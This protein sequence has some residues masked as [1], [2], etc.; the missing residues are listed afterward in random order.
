MRQTVGASDHPSSLQQGLPRATTGPRPSGLAR[1]GER[2]MATGLTA[3][4]VDTLQGARAGSTRRQ[5]DSKWKQFECW[6]MDRDPQVV[7]DSAPVGAVLSFLQS[8]LERGRCY[9]TIKGLVK[10]FL[11]AVK[12]RSATARPLVPAW[13]LAVVLD[14]LCG[15]QFEPIES[16]SLR[17]LSLKTLFLLAITTA[18]RVSD[19]Q[20]LSIHE[21]CFRMDPE[22]RREL[23]QPDLSFVTKN[24]VV[25][26]LPVALLAYHPPPFSSPEDKRLHCLC[27]V[28]VLRQYVRRTALFRGSVKQLF[29]THGL[30]K[31]AGKVAA[32]PT[33]YRWQSSWRIHPRGWTCRMVSRPIP[34]GQ[35][36]LRGLLL[37][38]SPSLR[39][40]W[41]RTGHL[42]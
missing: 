16:L 1:I 25:A 30:G 39:S 21:H 40:V 37:R 2:L 17:M 14:A 13:D 32:T 6:C 38:V 12:R 7:P 28:R 15:P 41:L 8:I 34:P 24:Q 33:L 27:P 3:E 5:Y 22:G 29:V 35:W 10:D 26:P 11:K 4:V 42:C 23:M 20:A 36:P 9:T 19:L 31:A 18:K